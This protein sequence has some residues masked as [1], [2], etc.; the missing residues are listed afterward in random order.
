MCIRD[1]SRT[2]DGLTRQE[3]GYVLTQEASDTIEEY[4][5]FAL[6][7]D[8]RSLQAVWHTQNLPEEIPLSYDIQG[9]SWLT[10]GYLQEYP[11]TTAS[12][13]DGLLVMGYPKD[14]YWTVSYTHLVYKRQPSSTA[15]SVVPFRA[16]E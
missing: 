12:H 9:I 8:Q 2:A 7:I 6:L 14:S 15:L 16:L 11:T 4:Q 1:S 5:A 13:P 10:R 3:E